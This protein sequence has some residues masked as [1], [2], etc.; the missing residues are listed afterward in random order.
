LKNCARAGGCAGTNYPFLT[1]KER[2]NETGLDYFR[3]RYYSNVHGRFTST[4]K[5]LIDQLELDPQSWNLYT[6]VKNNP[7]RFVDPTENQAVECNATCQESKKKAEEARKQAQTEGIDVVAI[8]RNASRDQ[9]ITEPSATITILAVCPANSGCYRSVS[10]FGIP[11]GP[12]PIG[13][14]AVQNGGRLLSKL[15]GWLFRRPVAR[16]V[17]ARP[18]NL[19]AGT[20]QAVNRQSLLAGSQRT[21]DPARLDSIRNFLNSGGALKDLEAAEKL[22]VNTQGVIVRGHHRAFVAAERG[23]TVEVEVIDFAM[24]AGPL[25]TQVPLRY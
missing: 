1:Q 13:G 15:F 20:R 10:W 23:L 17:V 8:T 5:P 9:E 3:A 4:D 7:L 21:L 14:G 16:Q 6:S 24:E 2:D 11:V 19:I 25:I 12:S 22:V 18:V